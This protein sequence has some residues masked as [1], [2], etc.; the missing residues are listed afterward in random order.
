MG[1]QLK[2]GLGGSR[3]G[4]GR[5]EPTEYLKEVSKG[6]RRLEDRRVVLEALEAD[7]EFEFET[8]QPERGDLNLE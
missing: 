2:P 3:S 6:R 5:R 4:R 8:P 7:N 1:V